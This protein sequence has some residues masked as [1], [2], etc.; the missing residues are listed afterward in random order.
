[1]NRPLILELIF[2][3]PISHQIYTHRGCPKNEVPKNVY[4]F[5]IDIKGIESIYKERERF[6]DMISCRCLFITDS[7]IGFLFL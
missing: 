6:N 1:M 7:Y 5:Y 2:I 4:T 3:Y